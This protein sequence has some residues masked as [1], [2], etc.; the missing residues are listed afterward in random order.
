[1]NWKELRKKG[2]FLVLLLLVFVLFCNCFLD[3]GSVQ[4]ID[5][6][7]V[8]SHDSCMGVDEEKAC[9]FLFSIEKCPF[10]CQYL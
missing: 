9:Y 7:G 8:K 3:K 6:G 1:M 2:S 10:C 5:T 4:K